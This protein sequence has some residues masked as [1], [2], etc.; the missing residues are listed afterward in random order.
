M[1]SYFYVMLS[2]AVWLAIYALPASA[3]VADMRAEVSADSNLIHH[4]TFEGATD[5]ERLADKVSGGAD[6]SVIGYGTGSATIGAANGIKFTGVTFDDSTV[7][8]TTYREGV[9]T[10]GGAGL[11][12]VSDVALPT[13]LTVEAI[14]RPLDAYTGYD[15]GHA[16][17]THLGGQRGYFI[18]SM[19]GGVD[20]DK[21]AT[22]VGSSSAK[23]PTGSFTSGDW[24]YVANTYSVSGGNTTITSYMANIT[25]GETTL[26]K[27][28]DGYVSA[29]VYG[30]PAPL[31]VGLADLSK[32]YAG[33]A[34]EHC[35][36]FNG[37]ID[38]V[39]LYG[40]ALG[41]AKI[42]SHFEALKAVPEPGTL[43][44][45][46]FGGLGLVVGYIWRKA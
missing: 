8:L 15:I 35:L 29:G 5:S 38:E 12:T 22:V 33:T 37:Q 1:R 40:T 28:L 24:Y 7:S 30:T 20:G 44:L 6:L 27:V 34:F 2:L 9:N 14:I 18:T 16:V 45:M 13:S 17:M 26:T 11:S 42:E 41:E 19:D 32:Q 10:T 21:L 23:T 3:D 31:G 43:V 4:Y 25:L 36:A 46:A 39:A